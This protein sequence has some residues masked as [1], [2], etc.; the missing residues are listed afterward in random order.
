VIRAGT[1]LF[2]D[3]SFGVR[4]GG[5]LLSFIASWFVW[6]S[7]AILLSNEKAGA[8]ACLLFNLTLM[9]TV[10][11]MAATPDAPS[12]ATAA[13]FVFYLAKLAE[14]G[15]GRWWLAAGAAAGLGLLSKYTALFLGA[16]ALVWILASP[17]MRRWLV[18]PW[19]YLGGVIT[20]A[21]FVPNLMWNARH[22]WATFAFQFGR[23]ENS[24]FTLRY[25]ADFIGAQ[26]I[27]ATPFIF[28]LGV[29]GL[30][31]ASR[32]D[33]RRALIGALLWP[34]IVYF[35]W[36]SLHDRVQGNWPCFLYPIFA[37]A[38]VDAALRADWT[39]WRAPLARWSWRLAI[40]L[41]AVLLVAGYAQALI[42]V[43]PMGR[44]DPLARLLAVGFPEV[45]NQVETLRV[46]TGADVILTSDYA[47][48]A[49]LSFYGKAPVVDVGEDYRW[50]E[51]P[52]AGP[53]LFAKPALYVTELRKDRHDLVATGFATLT[54]VGHI[55]RLR[56]GIPIAHYVVYR[57]AGP[58]AGAVGRVLPG[59][60]GK[61]AN[62]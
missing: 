35:V 9:V 3:T 12:I 32:V 61:P 5:I 49:W 30:A 39:S 44:K 54:V 22:D 20:V 25:L 2:G 56:K 19:P 1:A 45:V 33:K 14:S 26:L 15:N 38:A 55:D 29:M 21:L 41:A 4:S 60:A 57:M 23:V 50:T 7:A 28:I 24:H 17:E 6:R 34:S 13:A 58:K 27:L 62:T 36:H 51:A 31:R 10:E 48:A 52:V 59:I 47:T 8:L 16:G 37:V 18:S 42:G 40:P 11:T 43:V 46:Q 53:A